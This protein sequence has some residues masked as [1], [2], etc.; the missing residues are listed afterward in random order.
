MW[1]LIL[2]CLSFWCLLRSVCGL[3]HDDKQHKDKHD[4]RNVWTFVSG[5]Q[6]KYTIVLASRNNTTTLIRIFKR[7]AFACLFG[8]SYGFSANVQLMKLNW[9]QA[10]K[11]KL[12]LSLMSLNDGCIWRLCHLKSILM[13]FRFLAFISHVRHKMKYFRLSA[14][15]S[16]WKG[17]V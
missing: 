8:E 9:K 11:N 13:L 15:F 6:Q 17:Y 5:N 16:I 3:R 12:Y 4:E 1:P 14:N 2:G 10:A 7:K